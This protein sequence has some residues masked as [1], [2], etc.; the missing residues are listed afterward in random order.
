MGVNLF[1]F[2]FSHSL[3]D[4][5]RQAGPSVVL[6]GNVP[7]RDVLFQGTPEDVRRSVAESLGSIEDR[8]RILVSAGGGVPPGVPTANLEALCRGIRGAK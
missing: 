6:V 7:P 1:N 2:S 3:S 5:R 4:M 8:R